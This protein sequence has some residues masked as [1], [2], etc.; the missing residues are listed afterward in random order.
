MSDFRCRSQNITHTK[1]R[2]AELNTFCQTS[3]CQHC[4]VIAAVPCHLPWGTDRDSK[5]CIRIGSS[6]K[7][8]T[9][10]YCCRISQDS[11]EEQNVNKDWVA[12]LHRDSVEESSTR[13]WSVRLCCDSV[14]SSDWN[15]G[16]G[17]QD[18]ESSMGLRN[19]QNLGEGGDTPEAINHD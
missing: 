12:C 17:C 16:S 15:E 2:Q 5:I 4:R 9:P 8:A 19:C 14:G 10:D 7:V 11:I 3:E 6:C 1:S 13:H 18:N